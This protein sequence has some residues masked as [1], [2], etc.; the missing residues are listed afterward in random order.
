MPSLRAD[1]TMQAPRRGVTA[2]RA[3][4]LQACDSETNCPLR[5]SVARRSNSA[6]MVVR[7]VDPAAAA[8]PSRAKALRA[9]SQAASAVIALVAQKFSGS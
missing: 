7:T 1:M 8:A 6:P 3:I 2:R 9:F 5:P 4:A